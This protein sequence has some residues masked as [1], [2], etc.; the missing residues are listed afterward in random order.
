[1]WK[2]TGSIRDSDIPSTIQG[3][4]SPRLDRLENEETKWLVTLNKAKSLK[5]YATSLR[6]TA[7]SL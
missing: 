5:K 4:I 3:V 7:L 1:M 2:P 6:I